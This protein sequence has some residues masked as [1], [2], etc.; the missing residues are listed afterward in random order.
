LW[1]ILALWLAAFVV[2]THVAIVQLGWKRAAFLTPFFWTGLEY[3]RSELY[4]LKFSWLNVGYAFAE[5]ALSYRG[6]LS[7]QLWLQ[8]LWSLR[9]LPCC[10]LLGVTICIAFDGYKSFYCAYYLLP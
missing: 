7:E 9:L 10:S 1:L 3:F 6:N 4:Y 8:A 2:I 5:S